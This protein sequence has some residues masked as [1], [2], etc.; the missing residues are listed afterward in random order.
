MTLTPIRPLLQ[1]RPSR[2]RAPFGGGL[3]SFILR[4]AL[5]RRRARTRR[6]LAN[7]SDHLLTDIGLSAAEGRRES[8]RPFWRS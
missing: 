3:P 6:Q 2:L 4:L 5:W 7:L 8:A 1:S